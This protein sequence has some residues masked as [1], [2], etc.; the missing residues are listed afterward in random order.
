MLLSSTR[1]IEFFAMMFRL[2]DFD[3]L[4]YFADLAIYARVNV[5]AEIGLVDARD[6]LSFSH[7]GAFLDYRRSRLTRVLLE[8]DAHGSR[9]MRE[10]REGRLSVVFFDLEAL[11]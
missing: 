2:A 10:I 3:P 7:L 9:A 5:S 1:P 6:D 8:L 4:R 11:A